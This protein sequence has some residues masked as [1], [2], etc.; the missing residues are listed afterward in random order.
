MKQQLNISVLGC[1]WLGLPLAEALVL[2]GCKVQGSTTSP[3]KLEIL[4]NKGIDPYLVHFSKESAPDLNGL[5]ICDVL[6]V[7][8]PP[9]GR[10][11]QGEQNYR[12]MADHLSDKIPGTQLEKII[13]I[14]STSVYPESN[15]VITESEIAQPETSGG[16]LLKEVE[17]QFLSVPGKSV[18]VLRLAGLVGPER[19]PG[20]F[21][22][23]KK[24]I[25]NG[26]A[27][28]NLIHRDDVI[29]IIERIIQDDSTAGVYN[30]CSPSHPSKSD[31]Y[32]LAAATLGEPVPEFIPE[33][34]NWKIISGKRV[35]DELNYRFIYPDIER[36]L[37]EMAV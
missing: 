8:V 6:I 28:V 19:H 7:A 14:S 35:N 10:T 3:E 22:K 17:D 37:K 15:S 32:R 20:R 23:G 24:G 34:G 1:G 26:L 11:P 36:W 30:A 12:Q 29:G 9:S 27:P 2:S 13:F 31:F 16:R 18:I 4:R 21:F 25:P 33:K 5:L